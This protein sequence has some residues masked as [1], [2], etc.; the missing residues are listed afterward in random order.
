M[1]LARRW[2]VCIALLSLATDAASQHRWTSSD[3]SAEHAPP[4]FRRHSPSRSD[5]NIDVTYYALN[6]RL[7]TAPNFLGGRVTI[8]ATSQIDNLTN[9][10][11]DLAAPMSVDSVRVDGSNSTFTRQPDA[12]TINLGRPYARGEM[13]TLDVNY[14]GTPTGGGFGSFV[15]NTH[16]NLPWVWTLSEPYGARDWW[17]NKDHPSDKA[18]SVD[19]ILTHNASVTFASNGTLVSVVNNGDGTATT[20][21]KTR[22]PIASYLI[23]M[24]VGSFAQFS[25]WFRYTPTDSMEVRNYVLPEHLSQAQALF[26]RTVGMLELFSN[27]FGLYPF[28][29]EK[30]GHVEFGWG[31]AME[32]QTLTSIDFRSF[33]EYTVAHELAH[34]WF[35]D[36]IT[37]R[38]WPDIWLNEGFASYCEAL[39]AE[40]TYGPAAYHAM[41]NNVFMPSARDAV[42][43]LRVQDTSTVVTLFN[44]N[45]VYRKGA[46]VLH[47]LRHVLGDSTFI[48]AMRAY[49]NE[50]ALRYG[51]ASTEDF[52]A[53][54]ERVSGTNLGWFFE[55][56]V[57]GE[58]YP[59]YR[60]RWNRH[61]ASAGDSVT[62][63]IDQSTGTSNPPYFVMPIDLRFHRTDGT[64]TTV[65]VFDDAPHHSF[66]FIVSG[67]ITSVTLDPDNWILK[68]AIDVSI[69]LPDGFRLYQN[70]PNPFNSTTVIE[71]DLLN[72]SRVQ[73]AVFNTLGQEVARIVD[74]QLPPG[75]YRADFNALTLPSGI[76]FY[77]LSVSH[78]MP[79]AAHV[80]ASRKM[81]LAK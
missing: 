61:A 50:P 15:F 32:H 43:T 38:T 46:T 19:F 79:P 58:K 69:G 28:I 5:H 75:S 16:D 8:R 44:G 78:G 67:Q 77:R 68:T 25:N 80:I 22:Y 35:G 62:V 64:D 45:L 42:G 37:M 9:V 26:P 60:Y 59:I 63:S 57:Y 34:H 73:L 49:A 3:V 51:N 11:L 1:R 12:V 20:H 29:D 14:R 17:P 65:S 13:I 54:C 66:S 39:Y 53:V 30:Y 71:Y 6:L 52:R 56:W 72:S 41:F 33:N 40:H 36:M 55:Q 23:A 7:S 47:M 18:D 21:W 48:R 24:T 10:Q 4:M 70:Y 76:Y 74:Q 2:F 31:G 81:V 27:L